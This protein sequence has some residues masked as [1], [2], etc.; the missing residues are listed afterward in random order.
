MPSKIL[1][2]IKFYLS[3]AIAFSSVAGFVFYSG[4]LNVHVFSCAAGV[5]LLACA[6][7]V[8]NQYQEREQDALMERT[9]SRPIPSG[10][11]SPATAAVIAVLSGIAGTGIL[12]AFSG[13]QP[14][15]L[16]VA[17]LAWYNALYTP[18]KKRSSFAVIIGAVNGAVPPVI[19]WTAA[20]GDIADP[21]ILFIAFFIFVWQVPHFWLLLLLHGEDYR[22]AG[23]R[24]ATDRI[25]A[26]ARRLILVSWILATTVSALFLPLF[27]IVTTRIVVAAIITINVLSLATL[28][29]LL[30][31]GRKKP[32]YRAA[33]IAFN[34]FMLLVFLLVILDRLG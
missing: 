7:S 13:W 33:F 30:H 6:A 23:F 22:K 9:R 19:G 3:L 11:I 5:F 27:G 18:L 28:A 1:S 4:S 12:W 31:P 16:G 17:N 20:G 25:P 29:V 32:G 21:Q 2:L 26:P 14:A 24:V 15:L 34:L 8:L 10:T